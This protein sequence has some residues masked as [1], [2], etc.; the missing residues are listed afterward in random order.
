MTE[1]F[2]LLSKCQAT[3]SSTPSR[4]GID[5][6]ETG[7]VDM[8]QSNG[9][10]GMNTYPPNR[11]LSTTENVLRREISPGA[12]RSSLHSANLFDGTAGQETGG[13]SSHTVNHFRSSIKRKNVAG[14]LGESS[15]NGSSRNHRQNNNML[16]PSLSSHESTA[17][18]NMTSVNYGFSYPPMEQ[19]EQN[20]DTSEDD[21]F[22]DP[23]TLS[24]HLHESERFLRNTRMRISAN[25]YEQSLTNL[26]PEESF[27]CSAH[28]P[29]QQQSSFTPVQPR[30]AS[31][32]ASSQNRPH[33][34]AVA[35]FSQS[36]QRHPSNGNFSS[37]VG[38]SADTINPRPASQDRSRR[39]R[40][41]TTRDT[42]P[43]CQPSLSTQHDH[44]LGH[45]GCYPSIIRA[46]PCLWE[47]G[48]E[49]AVAKAPHPPPP[50]T[51]EF[52]GNDVYTLKVVT[53]FANGFLFQAGGKIT[54]AKN[55]LT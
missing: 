30:G 50:H 6:F 12:I 15:A 7:N 23:Y 22:S 11:G 52:H 48:G 47:R 24:G 38:S 54:D 42:R 16:L 35:Q 37:R 28:Q 21:I 25:E 55:N 9:H 29:A 53:K 44:P 20:T 5:Q 14:S 41:I 33:V 19:L 32:S 17:N 18:L 4:S 3:K 45:L 46:H 13:S 43:P 49:E 36:L 26:L 51:L 1:W 40:P 8:V 27:R 31:S 2:P 34:P 39:K 10:S